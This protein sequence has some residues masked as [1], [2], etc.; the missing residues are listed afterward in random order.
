MSLCFL[1]SHPRGSISCDPTI[2]EVLVYGG[3]ILFLC[4]SP[5]PTLLLRIVVG[6]RFQFTANQESSDLC[7]QVKEA[8]YLRNDFPKGKQ[9]NLGILTFKSRRLEFQPACVFP[10]I[11]NKSLLRVKHESGDRDTDE[12][13]HEGIQI[14]F[15]KLIFT[16]RFT[17]KIEQHPICKVPCS[18][19]TYLLTELPPQ[20]TPCM[21]HLQGSDTLELSIALFLPH[22]YVSLLY[23][24]QCLPEYFLQ[25]YKCQRSEIYVTYTLR[26]HRL[27]VL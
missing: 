14:Q 25:M 20:M 3:L 19:W 26:S 2:C 24:H 12:I 16:S 9:K 15:G 11:F 27:L 1:K 13:S 17:M 6:L 5:I 22:V 10:E 7:L 4:L 18:T 21:K 23:H 8:E